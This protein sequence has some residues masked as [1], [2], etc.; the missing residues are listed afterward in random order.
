MTR[1][2]ILTRRLIRLTRRQTLDSAS[3]A[4]VDALAAA[5]IRLTQFLVI[6]SLEE[7]AGDYCRSTL[8]GQEYIDRVDGAIE[9][10]IVCIGGAIKLVIVCIMMTHVE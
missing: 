2:Q 10:V 5:S 6:V 7:F 3:G 9:L 8:I 1:C 4:L